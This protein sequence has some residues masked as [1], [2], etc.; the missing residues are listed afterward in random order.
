MATGDRADRKNGVPPPSPRF[1][2]VDPNAMPPNPSIGDL[3]KGSHGSGLNT[4]AGKKSN[5]ARP[6]SPAT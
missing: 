1:P 2:L 6:R 5:W 4:G 3:V